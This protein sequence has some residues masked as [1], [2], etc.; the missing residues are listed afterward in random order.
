[1]VGSFLTIPVLITYLESS[2]GVESGGR[3]GLTAAA[4]AV[5]FLL[6]LAVTPLALMIPAAATSPVLIY[7]GVS[8]MKGLKNLNYEELS[9]YVPA[10]LCIALS[11]FTFNVGNGIAAAFIAYVIIRLAQGEYRSLKAG[12]YL[13]A[14]V[15]SYYFY[16][17]A[18]LK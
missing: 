10:F 12:H 13:L 17:L 18:F 15:L 5:L 2:A 7:V 4:A 16:A 1:M 9:E 8:M 14:L 6:V 3:T 11:V